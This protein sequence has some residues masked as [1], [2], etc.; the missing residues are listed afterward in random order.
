MQRRRF[1]REFKVETVNISCNGFREG[2][3]PSCHYKLV[4]AG[5]ISDELS[6]PLWKNIPVFVRPKSPLELPP[7]RA[8]PRGALRDRHGRWARDAMDAKCRALS[9]ARTSGGL[10]TAKSCGPG[11]PTLVPSRWTQVRR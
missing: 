1:T 8:P 5:Q 4:P 7:S 6:S 10:R 11:A 3:T 2:L 9:L